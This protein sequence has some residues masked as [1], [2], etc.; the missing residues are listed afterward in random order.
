M[1]FASIIFSSITDDIV[2]EVVIIREAYEKEVRSFAG[3]ATKDEDFEKI[4][5]YFPSFESILEQAVK[6]LKDMTRNT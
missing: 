3:L 5:A 6:E 2:N 4:Q 1:T